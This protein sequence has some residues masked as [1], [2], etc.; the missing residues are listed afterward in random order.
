MTNIGLALF[1]S[2]G[3]VSTSSTASTVYA[4][5][6]QTTAGPITAAMNDESV[7]GP[8]ADCYGLSLGFI[9]AVGGSLGAVSIGAPT[10]Q[11]VDVHLGTAATGPFR[12]ERRRAISDG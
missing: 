9:G 1:L 7:V 8:A 10:V 4:F 2:H 5:R 12:N 6:G 11:Y 3:F